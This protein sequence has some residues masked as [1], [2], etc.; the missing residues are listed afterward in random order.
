MNKER[1]EYN[2]IEY[3]KESQT[4]DRIFMLVCLHLVFAPVCYDIKVNPCVYVFTQKKGTTWTFCL[5][6][7][8]L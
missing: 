3:E 5:S 8:V 2:S 6:A 4:N 1:D 7:W